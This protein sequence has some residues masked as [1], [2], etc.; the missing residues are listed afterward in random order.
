MRLGTL[1][2]ESPRHVLSIFPPRKKKR[3][4]TQRR[5]LYMGSSL[6]F[7]P[8]AA[9]TVLRTLLSQAPLAR[10]SAAYFRAS[11][12]LL[13][14]SFDY[15]PCLAQPKF[16]LSLPKTSCELP[17]VLSYCSACA[18]LPPPTR[19]TASS[20]HLG[21]NNGC[22]LSSSTSSSPH[23]SLS[24]HHDYESS[25]SSIRFLLLTWLTLQLLFRPL[26]PDRHLNC[27]HRK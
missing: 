6:A 1:L 11:R 19:F 10:S 20:S 21:D 14:L 13:T 25:S 4:G 22:R 8:R 15:S 24:S 23:H 12:P 26:H 17:C 18:F 7:V 2:S 9:Y 27:L 16:S 3:F 5:H